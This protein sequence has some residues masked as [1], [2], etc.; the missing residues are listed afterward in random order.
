MTSGAGRARRRAILAAPSI[1]RWVRVR[2]FIAGALFTGLFAAMSY[3]AYSIGVVKADYYRDAAR[4]Q[5]SSTVEVA[6]PRGAILDATGFELAATANVESVYANPREVVDV[7]GTAERLAALLDV[8]VR[9]L[10]SRLSSSRYFAWVKRRVSSAEARAIREA[11]LAGVALTRE[12]RRFYPARSLA[13]PVLGFAN[14]DGK[15]IEGIEL[16]MNDLLA[17][18]RARLRGLRDAAGKLMLAEADADAQSRAGATIELTL[19]RFVQMATETALRKAVDDNQALAGTAVVLDVRDG[20]VLAMASFPT[21][22]PNDPRTRIGVPARNRAVTDTFE[23][24]SVMKVFTVAAALDAGAVRPDQAIDVEKGRYRIGRKVYRDTH[25]DEVLSVGGVIKRSSNVGAIKIAFALGRQKLHQAIRDYGFGASTGIE[26]PGEQRGLVRA[27]QRWGDV[28][29]A[30]MSMGY[31]MTATPIQLAQALAAVGNGGVLHEPR[32]VRRVVASSGDVLYELD[33]RGRRIM[34]ESTAR[35]LLPMLASVFDKGRRDGGT[36]KTIDIRGFRAGG[37]TGTSYKVNPETR[38]YYDD[39]YLSSFIGLAPIDDPRIAVVVVIDEPGG[40]EHYGGLVAGPVFASIV[41]ESLPYL[42]VPGRG[43]QPDDGD[44]SRE[45]G[46]G[47]AGNDSPYDGDGDDDD[48]VEWKAPT[49]V[50]TLAD[51]DLPEVPNF[52]GM[53]LGQAV[54]AAADAGVELAIEGSGRAVAQTPMAGR[55]ARHARVVFT[56]AR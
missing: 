41:E 1:G 19:D 5:H 14:I 28:G 49:P 30:S 56:P 39:K 27:P 22:D 35:A 16:A 15:G 20:T 54:T 4:R 26:L 7:I 45:T 55:R 42:G 40:E 25:R 21:Y 10:E 47:G 48:E 32:L 11:K 51:P 52:A 23:A 8:D 2:L 50:M 33:N 37:K 53:S 36:A 38:T 24:G 31:G 29:L 18:K 46:A 44:S 13:G 9:T 17:G 3:K 6:A 34:K 12:P 43:S